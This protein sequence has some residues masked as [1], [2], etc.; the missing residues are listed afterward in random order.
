MGYFPDSF[1]QS[2]VIMKPKKG[3]NTNNPLNY[4]PISLL[5]PITKIYEKIIN[6]RLKIYLEDKNLLN[7]LQFGFRLGRS[8]HTTLHTIQEYI[9]QSHKRDLDVFLL[10]R[11]IAKPIDK[12]HHPS[13]IYKIFNNLNLPEL[14]CKTLANFLDNR[15]IKFTLKGLGAHNPH[16]T[17]S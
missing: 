7:D 6:Q 1:K 4:R 11:D 16:L 3:K 10:S 13:L 9:A 12:V 5:E 14:L 8:T 17:V 15:T 2:I